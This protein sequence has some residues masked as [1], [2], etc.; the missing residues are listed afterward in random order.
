M[1]IFGVLYGLSPNIWVGITMVVITG[2][3]QSPSSIAR[4][5]ILQKNT[6]REMRG[7]VFSAFFVARDAIFL[8]GMAG[9]GLA[10]VVDLGSSSSPRRSSSSGRASW[11]Q[12]MPGLGHAGRRVAPRGASSSAVPHVPRSPPRAARRPRPTST[13]CSDSVPELAGL[14]APRRAAFLVGAT[15]PPRRPGTA[16][17]KVGDAGDAAFFVLDGRAVAGIPDADGGSRSLSA[18]GPGD[19]FGEIAAITGSTRTANVLADEPTDLIEVPATTLKALM[20]VPAMDSLIT[21]KL[22]ER[23]TRTANADLIRLAGLDQRDLKDLR[24]RRR[25]KAASPRRYTRGLGR[26]RDRDGDART[27]GRIDPCR[28]PRGTGRIGKTPTTIGEIGSSDS[29]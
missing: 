20:D 18:M 16:I 5:V 22:R 25:P 19:F 23:L 17:V 26:V 21:S 10:D 13:G 24:R 14:D 4:R 27:Q 11:T 3:L 7:R 28:Q 29:S 9:A 12:L 2:F 15:H 8:F 6:P 1:G